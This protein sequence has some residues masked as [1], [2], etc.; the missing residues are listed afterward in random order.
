MLLVYTKPNDETCLEAIK[1][2]DENEIDYK[3][4]DISKSKKDRDYWKQAGI[5]TLPIFEKDNKNWVLPMWDR[6]IFE[7]LMERDEI[8]G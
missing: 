5:N 2:L 8:Y 3:E 7:F 4:I 1:Y 6:E